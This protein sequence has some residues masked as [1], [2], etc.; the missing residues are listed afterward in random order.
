ME[1]R[2]LVGRAEMLVDHSR[3][4]PADNSRSKGFIR[5]LWELWVERP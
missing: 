3:T 1:Y 5:G 2:D 4:G